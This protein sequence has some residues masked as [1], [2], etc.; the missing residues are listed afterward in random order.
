M[1][2]NN[3]ANKSSIFPRIGIQSGMKSIGNARYAIAATNRHTPA[4]ISKCADPSLSG[5]AKS[6]SV[7][8]WDVCWRDKGGEWT[9]RQLDSDKQVM[10]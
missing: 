8:P 9:Y 2:A 5:F 3:P 1:P 7:K 10:C 4:D 6:S